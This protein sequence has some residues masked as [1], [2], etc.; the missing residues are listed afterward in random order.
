VFVF[1]VLPLF[2]ALWGYCAI[3]IYDCIKALVAG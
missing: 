3:A 2:V 1:A